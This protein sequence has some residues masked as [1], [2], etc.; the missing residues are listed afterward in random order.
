VKTVFEKNTVLTYQALTV[1]KEKNL[2]AHVTLDGT[3]SGQTHPCWP[4]RV[5]SKLS[6]ITIPKDVGRE[7]NECLLDCPQ[8]RTTAGSVSEEKKREVS[9][10]LQ[11]L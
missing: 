5:V 8:T 9:R 11:P 7:Q 2:E 6:W 3:L 4:W 10:H 1:P